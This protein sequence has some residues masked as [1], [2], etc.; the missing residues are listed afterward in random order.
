MNADMRSP[1]EIPPA[2]PSFEHDTVRI[3]VRAS[4]YRAAGAD[5]EN[6]TNGCVYFT[7]RMKAITATRARSRTG[8][9]PPSARACGRLLYTGSPAF[10][11][12]R[13]TCKNAG[14]RG[15]G[16]R[17]LLSDPVSPRSDSSSESVQIWTWLSVRQSIIFARLKKPNNNLASKLRSTLIKGSACTTAGR[18]SR[19]ESVNN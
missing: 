18:K 8:A 5:A 16:A 2:G 15:R 1:H 13:R 19:I 3:N 4:H 9:P 17:A 7:F 10:R 6:V 12:G 11:A 14:E